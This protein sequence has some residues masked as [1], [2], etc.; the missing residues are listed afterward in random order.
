MTSG[1]RNAG[2]W[3][4]IRGLLSAILSAG[5]AVRR[6]FETVTALRGLFPATEFVWVTGMDNALNFHKWYRWRDI[7]VSYADRAC[8]AA[9]GRP[10]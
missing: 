2:R 9:A 5:L 3:R 1:W 8:R 7:L 10:P 4:R 6:S